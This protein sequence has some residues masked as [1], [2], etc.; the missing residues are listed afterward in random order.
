MRRFR[1]KSKRVLGFNLRAGQTWDMDHHGVQQDWRSGGGFDLEL[2]RSTYISATI[3]HNFE[4]FQNINFHRHD[5]NIGLHTE[6][7]KRATFDFS[8]ASGTRIN[9]NPAAGLNPFLAN[10]NELQAG[11]TLR[12]GAFL[13]EIFCGRRI[14]SP[15]LPDP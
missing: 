5:A 6:Y 15:A 13:T 10:G 11:C 2:V 8:Y 4:R 1:P 7:F 3:A 12:P 9:Y 14:V